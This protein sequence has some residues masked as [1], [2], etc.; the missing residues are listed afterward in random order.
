MQYVYYAISSMS[1]M[2]LIVVGAHYLQ[3]F[4]LNFVGPAV[5]D[6]YEQCFNH[7]QIDSV[8]FKLLKQLSMSLSSLRQNY[9]RL[10]SIPQAVAETETGSELHR[11]FEEIYI[12]LTDVDGKQRL[13]EFYATTPFK[14][15]C[16]LAGVCFIL[17]NSGDTKLRDGT[18]NFLQAMGMMAD[19]VNL[20]IRRISLQ[21]ARFGALEYL[22]VAPL[23]AIGVIESF[24]TSIIPGT[25]VMY[26]GPIGYISR[27]VI[28]LA[29]IVGYTVIVKVNSAVSVRKDDRNGIVMFLLKREWFT[30]NSERSH[31]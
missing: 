2:V 29:S 30:K 18:S 16:T 12:I 13:E 14:L 3:R 23:L 19:E 27:T 17:N 5:R 7:K 15:L 20:E 6:Y 24:F 31:A 26:S 28:L 8:H 25:S 11:A 22:P 10:N 4:V 1:S 9:L 21:K